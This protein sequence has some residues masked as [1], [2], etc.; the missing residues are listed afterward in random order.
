MVA[1]V[2]DRVRELGRRVTSRIAHSRALTHSSRMIV[3]R[4]QHVIWASWRTL[5]QHRAPIAG[6][7]DEWLL[8]AVRDRIRRGALPL[9]HGKVTARPGTG[10][11]CAVCDKPIAERQ[12]EYEPRDGADAPDGM[13]G[14]CA[15]QACY[16]AWLVESQLAGESGLEPL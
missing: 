15:H 2:P 3:A 7:A 12:I 13:D 11:M 9:V 14:F 16:T 1:F 6:G 8:V 10:R 4:S 5:L